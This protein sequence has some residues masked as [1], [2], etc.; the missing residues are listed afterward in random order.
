VDLGGGIPAEKVSVIIEGRDSLSSSGNLFIPDEPATGSVVFTNLTDQEITVPAGTLISTVGEEPVSFFTLR[1]R[2]LPTSTLTST[3]PIQAVLPGVTGNVGAERL[4]AIEGPLGLDLT[5]VN[6]EKTSGGTGRLAPAPMKGDYAALSEK[7][8][9]DLYQSALLEFDA[10]LNPGDLLLDADPNDYQII[11]GTFTPGEIQ[12]AD[13][14]QLTLR[15]EFYGLVAKGADLHE[16]AR[17]VLEANIPGDFI[18]DPATIEIQHPEK[19]TLITE[20]ETRLVQATWQMDARWQV[21][22][23]LNESQAIRQVLWHA[24]EEAAAL[25]EANLPI[26]GVARINL[27]PRWWPRLPILPFRVTVTTN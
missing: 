12:P 21:S 14:L 19:F 11:E 23:T 16:L 15:V 27:T 6:P 2:T 20:G 26:E 22:A 8:L 7:M 24:P 9:D 18:P 1:D 13:Q 4:V 17:G 10:K 3:V 25:L 5:V